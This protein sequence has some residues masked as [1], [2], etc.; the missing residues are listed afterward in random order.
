MALSPELKE[1][2][3]DYL[4]QPL[5]NLPGMPIVPRSVPIP[6]FGN[7][8]TARVA[9]ISLNPSNLEFEKD[10]CILDPRNKR[11]T[12]REVLMVGD[13]DTLNDEQAA[14]VYDSHIGYFD[15]DRNPYRGWFDD[16]EN[17]ISDIF[18]ASYYNGTM[19]NLDIYPWATSMKWNGL[20]KY[21]KI[22]ATRG[23]KLLKDIL[24][25][26]QPV[27]DW[28]Y[29]NGGG[30]FDNLRDHYGIRIGEE[31]IVNTPHKSSLS[32]KLFH[33]VLPNGTKVIGF[34]CYIQNPW[35]NPDFLSDVHEV[36]RNKYDE[37]S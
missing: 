23:Y 31:F 10:G 11:F 18:N 17:Y 15:A 25:S 34:S 1:Q 6:F 37:M 24:T 28:V 5:P 13:N 30:V 27:F 22:N 20:D 7:I 29:I 14:R 2:I 16:L 3:I 36:L 4:K 9:T 12:D 35:E 8:E 32:R 33:G 19:V 21:A 26:P